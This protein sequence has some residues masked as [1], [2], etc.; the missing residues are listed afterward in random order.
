MQR[1]SMGIAKFLVPKMKIGAA[2]EPTAQKG[3][4][5]V[6]RAGGPWTWVGWK[7]IWVYAAAAPA[8]VK[9]ASL[10]DVNH[11]C[12]A[13]HLGAGHERRARRSH[14]AKVRTMAECMQ[15]TLP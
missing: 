15:A 1:S 13:A 11:T 4:L 3:V 10:L 2:Q 9:R 12:S 6:R 7:A 8:I 5:Q 14:Q